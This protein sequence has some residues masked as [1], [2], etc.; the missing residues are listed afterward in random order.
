MW[1][2]LGQRAAF[3]PTLV[4]RLGW[5][6]LLTDIASEMLYP[7]VPLFLFYTVGASPVVIGLIE[8]LAEATAGILKGVVGRLSDRVGRRREFVIAGYALSGCVK[9]LPGFF[10]LWQSVLFSKLVDRVG[11]ALRTAP[12]DALLAAAVP[13]AAYGRAFGFHRAMDTLGAVVGPLLALL[14][15]E[16]FPGAYREVFLFTLIP[17][18]L[19]I[20]VSWGIREP[21]LSRGHTAERVPSGGGRLGRG[22]WLLTLGW[23]LFSLGFP[24]MAFVLLRLRGGAAS[25]GAVLGGYVLYNA[26]YALA[27]F[28]LGRFADRVGAKVVA[29][30]GVVSC[31][32]ACAGLAGAWGSSAAVEIPLLLGL[33]IA[34]VE[35]ALRS[36]VAAVAQESLRATAFGIVSA[37]T[38]LAALGA[39]VVAGWLWQGWGVHAPFVWAV[40][41]LGAAGGVLAW[42]PQQRGRDA[43]GAAE[44]GHRGTA[45]TTP[46]E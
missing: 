8:G 36:W 2:V 16:W 20:A 7:V 32:V 39:G 17:S 5:V 37:V 42:V 21:A 40:A 45:G 26:V 41:L 25:D 27:A 3:L 10:P 23:A 6:S 13:Q 14:W 43:Q 30:L 19:A 38:S 31:G 12:R 18:A 15:L 46:M 33:G 29:L 11:K 35:T 1:R 44:A 22:F 24:G 4:V 34:A 28:P 9:P